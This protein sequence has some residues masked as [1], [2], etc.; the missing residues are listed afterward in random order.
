MA[1]I[2][3]LRRREN[4]GALHHGGQ[5]E[6][7]DILY[8]GSKRGMEKKMIK[9]IDVRFEGISCGKL[10]RYFSWENFKDF[11]RVPVG[12]FQAIGILRK[13]N[14]EVVFSKGG[15]V[16]VPVV[17]AAWVLRIPV[18]VHES[19]M[20]PGLANKIS[21]RFANKICLSFEESKK[22]LKKSWKKKAEVTGTP[23][24]KSIMDGDEDKGRKFCGFDKYRPVVLVMGGS[25]G[26]QQ[27][28]ELVRGSL[29]EL[30]KKFQI[31][32]ICGKGKLD[33]GIHKK[34]YKQ[35]EYLNK[36]LADVYSITELIISRAG[37]NSLAE[38][39]VLGKR[40]VIIPLGMEGSRGEQI[41]NARSYSKKY[42]W[43]ILN[44]EI[45]SEDFVKAVEMAYKNKVNKVKMEN[46]VENVIDVL[47]DHSKK[48]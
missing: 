19:D 30:L 14:P 48:S 33:M 32:H 10:R 2:E 16:G 23:I 29:D 7:V 21:F 44:G 45:A 4:E 35:F 15:F 8:I 37:A 46:G 31:V 39:A 9:K 1:V 18:V 36:E 27:I 26:A 20:E 12:F 13:Y 5:G 25:L 41:D 24:R 34:G 42:A 6:R 3:E 11:F 47:R 43:S 38:I 28:N 22:F 40:A 17:M